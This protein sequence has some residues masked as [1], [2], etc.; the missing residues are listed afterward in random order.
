MSFSSLFRKKPI[1]LIQQDAELASATTRTRTRAPAPAAHA[2]RHRPDGHGHRRHHRRRHLLD[3]R[4]RPF[5]GGPAVA[6]LFVFTAIACAFSA[7]CYAEFASKIP[8]AGS[9][10]T[11]AYASF[12]ELIAWI[13][14]W[15]C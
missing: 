7:L 12:G 3:H 9:A 13:I 10:Y 4:Q 15:T 5:N 11:Y 14:G 1:E 8:V 6:F 2:R